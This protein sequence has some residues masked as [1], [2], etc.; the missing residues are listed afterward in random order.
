[1]ASNAPPIDLRS[2]MAGSLARSAVCIRLSRVYEIGFPRCPEM[3]F[4]EDSNT[5]RANRVDL[6][7]LYSFV[8]CSQA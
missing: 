8:Q 4:A 7:L 5:A 2:V 1:M 3:A 6:S